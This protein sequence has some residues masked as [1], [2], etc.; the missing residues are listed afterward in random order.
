MS[1]LVI[2]IAYDI[3]EDKT[4]RRVEK[5]LQS[6]GSRLQYSLFEIVINTAAWPHLR[7][8]LSALICDETDR[9]NYYP[10]CPWC[11][12]R[13]ETQG[14]AMLPEQEAFQCIC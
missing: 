2:W 8:E 3:T 1:R 6:F 5:L 9:L 14:A 4:R 7:K 12:Q 13:C 11:R 10:L